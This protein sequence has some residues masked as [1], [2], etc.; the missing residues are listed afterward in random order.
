MSPRNHRDGSAGSST[1]LCRLAL[2]SA[3]ALGA[4]PWA[5]AAEVA[6]TQPTNEQT[7]HSNLGEVMVSV[8]VSDAAPGS[9]VRLSVDGRALPSDGGSMIALR[10]L[11]RGTHVLKAELLAADG[12]VVATSPPVTF[13]LWHASSRNPHRAK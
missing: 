3:L 9:R 11:D 6:I 4:V 7:I 1:R 5:Q 2:A 10:G 13:Y 12:Q 8:Q